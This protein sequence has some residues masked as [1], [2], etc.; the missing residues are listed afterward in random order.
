MK[1]LLVTGCKCTQLI[2]IIHQTNQ[3]VMQLPDGNKR[4][5]RLSNNT[6][7]DR[8]EV[9]VYNEEVENQYIPFEIKNISNS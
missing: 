8:I 6:V 9:L 1:A 4:R 3:I 5:F 2:D 7:I